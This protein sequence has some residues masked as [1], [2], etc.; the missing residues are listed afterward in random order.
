MKRHGPKNGSLKPVKR[1]P[2]QLALDR[3]VRRVERMTRAQL[4]QS[5]V[6][7]GIVTRAGKLAPM[8]R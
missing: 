3:A 1:V 4:S 2:L 7:A 5:L 6:D 8:Y